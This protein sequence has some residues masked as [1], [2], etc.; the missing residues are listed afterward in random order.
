M[1]SMPLPFDSLLFYFLHYKT[2]FYIICSHVVP[3]HSDGN[4]QAWEIS[5]NLGSKKILKPIL[6]LKKKSDLIGMKKTNNLS[7]YTSA[8]N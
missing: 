5:D 7:K 2:S 8:L 1:F 4:F 3:H 6:P